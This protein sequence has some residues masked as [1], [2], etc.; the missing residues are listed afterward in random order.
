ME[1]SV[2]NL[3]YSVT[4]VHIDVLHLVGTWSFTVRTTTG[5]AD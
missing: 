5:T 3:N 4:S 2:L 1:N